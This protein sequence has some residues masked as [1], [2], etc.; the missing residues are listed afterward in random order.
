MSGPASL[1]LGIDGGGTGCRARLTDGEG[2]VLGEGRAGPASLRLGADRSFVALIE[3]SM[4]ALAAAGLDPVADARRVAACAALAGFSRSEARE[5]LAAKPHP[6]GRLRLA[7]DIEAACIGAHDGAD[8]GIVVVG[9]GSCAFARVGSRHIRFGGWGLPASDE[10]SG[11]FLGLRAVEAAFRCLDGRLPPSAFFEAIFAAV[12]AEP[13]ALVAWV[14]EAGAT[15]LA[16]LAPLV[17]SAADGGD[18][19]A[20]AIMNEAA[21][22]VDGLAQALVA[23]GV[24]RIALVG[25]LADVMLP[26]LATPVVA[27]LGDP[28]DGALIL[29]RG[30]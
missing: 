12:P 16:S 6:F 4:A 28:L 22:A 14:D 17:V 11:S 15:G 19:T 9:T 25:G 7:P 2:R 21:R 1:R 5:A 3:A 20:A 13:A 26:R 24:P 29:A 18:R 27:P 8:G 23:A 30:P 10:G